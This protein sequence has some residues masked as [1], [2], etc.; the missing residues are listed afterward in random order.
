M[1]ESHTIPH[2]LYALLSL[3]PLVMNLHAKFD[4]SSSNCSRNME[5]VQKYQK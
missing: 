1:I 3:V 2:Q 5:K 4:F